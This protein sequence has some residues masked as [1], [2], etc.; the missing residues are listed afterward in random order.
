MAEPADQNAEGGVDV[1]TAGLPEASGTAGAPAGKID[2][3]LET[4][5][6]LVV[7]LGEAEM[8]VRDLLALGT[9]SVIKLDKLVGQPMDILLR[10]NKFAEGDLVIVGEQLGIRIKNITSPT[11]GEESAE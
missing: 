11:G 2:L 10:G 3:I 7:S 4:V 6:P 8:S 1:Q 9:G 5:M